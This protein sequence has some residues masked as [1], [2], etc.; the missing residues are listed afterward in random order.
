LNGDFHAECF[1]LD[2]GQGTGNLIVLGEGRVIVIDGGPVGAAQVVLTLFDD[3]RV[4]TIESLIVSH[5]DRDHC[6]GIGEILSKHH[7]KVRALYL[8]ID[9]EDFANNRFTQTVR[10]VDRARAEKRLPAIEKRWLGVESHEKPKVVYSDP[11]RNIRLELLHPNFNTIFDSASGSGASNAASAVL[12]LCCG[13]RSIVFPGDATTDAWETIHRQMMNRVIRCDLL[14]IPHHGGMIWGGGSETRVREKL[15][16][17]YSEVIQCQYAVISAGTSNGEG[18]PRPES[19]RAL[20]EAFTG[21]G[22]KPSVLCTQLTS[23]C[24]D[25]PNEHLPGIIEPHSASMSCLPATAGRAVAC[26]GT[27]I[28]EIGPDK[29]VIHRLADHRRGVDRLMESNARPLC[30]P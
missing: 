17:L 2:V 10:A 11:R 3:L 1:F 6:G 7:E 21:A 20:R 28:S 22:E 30:R 23:R 27:V 14:A 12:R 15:R 29:V 13:R 9:R 5:N 25:D 8:L 26:A 4:N 19:V 18:H 16:W 24:C